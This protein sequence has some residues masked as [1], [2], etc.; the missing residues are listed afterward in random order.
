VADREAEARGV[1]WDGVVDQ[2]A[3]ARSSFYMPGRWKTDK[4]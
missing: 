1:E 2:E 3:V 4:H